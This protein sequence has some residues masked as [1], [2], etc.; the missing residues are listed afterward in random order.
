MYQM[1]ITGRINKLNMLHFYFCFSCAVKKTNQVKK[2]LNMSKSQGYDQTSI[3]SSIYN[4]C[5]FGSA[6]LAFAWVFGKVV[7]SYRFHL[8]TRFCQTARVFD[9][10]PTLNGKRTA[11]PAGAQDLSVVTG[12]R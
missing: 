5:W 11:G 7:A 12:P 4:C 1:A 2:S 8:G 9:S 3:S 10:S 6:V